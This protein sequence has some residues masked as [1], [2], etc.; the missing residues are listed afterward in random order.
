MNV[1]AEIEPVYILGDFSLESAQKGWEIT[2]PKKLS[3]G[4]WRKQGL[5]FY[6]RAV[7]YSSEYIIDKKGS[8][9]VQLAD[10]DGV[11]AEV[12][13]NGQSAGVIFTPPFALDVSDAIQAGNNQI[14]VRV[15]G[16]NRNLLGPFHG[17]IPKGLS[18]PGQWMNIGEIPAGNAYQQFDY[19]LF[20]NFV[21][22]KGN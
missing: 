20:D 15:F 17:R 10:W 3:A 16:S 21:L 14:T 13:V 19:G 11:V 18:G 12:L 22:E 7:D 6:A 9:R 2:T 1:F 4:S 5:P 8:F